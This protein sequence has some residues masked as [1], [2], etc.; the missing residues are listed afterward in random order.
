M[1]IDIR[2]VNELTSLIISADNHLNS[3]K[4]LGIKLSDARTDLN[5]SIRC[6]VDSPV[7]VQKPDTYGRNNVVG[8]GYIFGGAELYDVRTR[9]LCKPMEPTREISMAFE[10]DRLPNE[11]ALCMLDSMK[12]YWEAQKEAAQ[13]VLTQILQGEELTT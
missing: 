13:T 10:Q 5:I 3:L 6:E 12:A 1:Q 11:L 4:K 2:K 7:G 8:G 9:D